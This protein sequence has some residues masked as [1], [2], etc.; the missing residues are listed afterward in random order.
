MKIEYEKDGSPR[1][2][3]ENKMDE[4]LIGLVYT[5]SNFSSLRMVAR[6]GNDDQK[7]KTEADLESTYAIA[8]S[9]FESILSEVLVDEGH[10]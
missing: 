10:T 3:A 1:M 7:T 5:A 2:S 9:R 4:F 6:T 8:K